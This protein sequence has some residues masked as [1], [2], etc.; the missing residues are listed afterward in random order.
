MISK[1]REFL[2]SL[3]GKKQTYMDEFYFGHLKDSINSGSGQV[4][5]P[6]PVKKKRIAKRKTKKKV[7]KES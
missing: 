1:L 7:E 4:D 3:F 2:N 6:K 5:E